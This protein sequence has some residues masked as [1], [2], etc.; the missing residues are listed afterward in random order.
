MT[1]TSGRRLGLA[2]FWRKVIQIR[3]WYRFTFS[4]SRGRPIFVILV[5]PSHFGTFFWL[6]YFSL[7]MIFVSRV[8]TRGVIVVSGWCGR[9]AL[10]TALL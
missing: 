4:L 8:A 1:A 3:L 5:P 9:L 7:L 2:L 10:R 6:R